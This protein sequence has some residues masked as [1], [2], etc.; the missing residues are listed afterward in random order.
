[1]CSKFKMKQGKKIFLLD[2]VGIAKNAELM[3][4]NLS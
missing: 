2:S 4:T 3:S 1:L